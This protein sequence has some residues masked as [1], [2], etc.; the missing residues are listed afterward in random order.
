MLSR[1]MVN[2]NSALQSA[3]DAEPSKMN[4][5]LAISESGRTMSQGPEH[6]NCWSNHPPP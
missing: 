6:P 1:A 4:G 3:Q 5:V 2:V